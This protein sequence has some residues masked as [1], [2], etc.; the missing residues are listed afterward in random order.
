MNDYD[1]VDI[2]EIEGGLL[3]LFE[4]QYKIIHATMIFGYYNPTKM[5]ERFGIPETVPIFVNPDYEFWGG[6]KV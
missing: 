2:F 1:T 4:F 6:Y 5:R 3:L